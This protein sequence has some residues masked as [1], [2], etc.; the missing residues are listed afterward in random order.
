MSVSLA[1]VAAPQEN[2]GLHGDLPHLEAALDPERM[3]D[4][5]DALLFAGTGTTLLRC[6]RPKPEVGDV[7]CSIHYPLLVRDASGTESQRLALAVMLPGEGDAEHFHARELSPIAARQPAAPA[8]GPRATGVLS[9][10]RLAVSL[11]PV[12]AAH[13][14]LV[15]AAD[16]ELA[17][18]ALRPLLQGSDAAVT[19]VVLVRLRRSRGCVLRYE[20]DHGARTAVFGK[21]GYPAAA[22]GVQAALDALRVSDG[23]SRGSVVFPRGL[24]RSAELD[25]T[26][27][28]ELPG[29]PPELEQ[30]T[31][32]ARVVDVA[33][34]VAAVL[35]A[36]GPGAGDEHGLDDEVARAARPVQMVAR[37]DAG[38]AGSLLAVLNGVTR[39]AAQA[40]AGEP[41]FS[42]GS[43]APSQLMFDGD[44]T[45]L[46]DFERVCRAEPGFDLGR[47]LASLR[48][49]VSRKGASDADALAQRF[50]SGYVAA[51]GSAGAAQRASLYECAAL[52]RTVAHSWL[53]LKTS[54]LQHA[55]AVLEARRE[56]LGLAG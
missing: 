28:E 20:L 23:A 27:V 13:P 35:H 31:E 15:L 38:L 33:A 1:Q 17:T 53:Q 54:R 50:L 48:T 30:E 44:R 4:E 43:F 6:G 18:A 34:A 40:P 52:I 25:E 46:L 56:S 42:H 37:Y 19:D 16:R 47:F 51:G 39:Q 36:S 7:G 22:A 29:R 21:V 49:S 55:L 11:F 9:H 32:R 45:G 10:L 14:T 2:A 5:L 12:S 8:G 24:G 41:V 26:F 3:R